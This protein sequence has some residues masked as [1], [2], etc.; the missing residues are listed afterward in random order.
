MQP[1]VDFQSFRILL[2]SLENTDKKIRLRPLGESWI[3]FSRVILLSDSAMIIQSDG[4]RKVI[5]NIKN[6]M[7]FQVEKEVSSFEPG[8]VYE[9]SY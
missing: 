6:V 4:E 7:E 5:I 8:T 1:K 2:E 9:V 3:D